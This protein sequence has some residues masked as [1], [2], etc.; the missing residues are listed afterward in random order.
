MSWQLSAF[1]LVACALLF[2]LWLI[3]ANMWAYIV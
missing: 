3:W 1:I 2:P